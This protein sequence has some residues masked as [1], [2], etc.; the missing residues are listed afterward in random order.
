MNSWFI[1]LVVCPKCKQQFKSFGPGLKCS[2]CNNQ[3]P[4]IGNIPRFVDLQEYE[5][6]G[7]QWNRFAKT[8]IDLYSKSKQ[9]E[10]RFKSETGYGNRIKDEIVLDIGCGSGRFADIALKEGAK[11][12]CMDLSSAVDACR[13][14][15]IDIGHSTKNFEVIQASI[16]SMPFNN[17][18]NYA[19]SL[20]V[21]QHTPNRRKAISCISNVINKEWNPFIVGV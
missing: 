18:F 20:G 19:Y 7:F 9:S 21:I 15:L 14:N 11:V 4:I 17:V 6:F 1:D 16:Y 10:R 13:K 8:Q 5:S 2:N 3:Y 12:I